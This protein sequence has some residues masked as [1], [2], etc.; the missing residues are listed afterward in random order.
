MNIIPSTVAGCPCIRRTFFRS[1][2]SLFF[3]F[4]F[5]FTKNGRP[6]ISASFQFNLTK[7]SKILFLDSR[8]DQVESCPLSAAF[9]IGALWL[10]QIGRVRRYFF[11]TSS[12][13][14]NGVAFLLHL[15]RIFIFVFSEASLQKLSRFSLLLTI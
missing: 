5:T 7:P 12:G 11:L 13:Q 9:I 3:F 15:F 10:S 1:Y 6:E 2:S 14:T 4:C 8:L